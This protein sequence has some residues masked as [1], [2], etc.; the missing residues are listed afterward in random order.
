MNLVG[1]AAVDMVRSG[2]DCKRAEAGHLSPGMVQIAGGTFWMGSDH[3]YPEEAPEPS[4]E[5]RAA[6]TTR[7]GLPT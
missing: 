6:L 5:R 2:V 4:R 3:H 7:A 1:L